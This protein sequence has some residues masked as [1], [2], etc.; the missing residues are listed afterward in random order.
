MGTTYYIFL[1]LVV[2]AFLA[3]IVITVFDNTSGIKRERK[4][5]RF[6]K[7]FKSRR[8]L[9]SDYVNN[10]MSNN[11]YSYSNLSKK[12]NNKDLYYTTEV[13][14]QISEPKITSIEDVVSTPIIK[15]VVS[16]DANE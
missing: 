6:D 3:C 15:S 4:V 10:N 16:F 9:Y 7:N 2:I 1:V 11:Y 14:I 8:S 13:N 12:I 5:K